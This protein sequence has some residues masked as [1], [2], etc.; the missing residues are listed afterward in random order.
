MTRRHKPAPKTF[1]QRQTEQRLRD[2]GDRAVVEDMASRFSC[3]S[4]VAKDFAGQCEERLV[5]L[6]FD[7]LCSELALG[8][9]ADPP[10]AA[11]PV[12]DALRELEAER[13]R[14]RAALSQLRERLLELTRGP[15]AH[16]HL[17]LPISHYQ[18]LIRDRLFP[19]LKLRPV[20]NP[21]VSGEH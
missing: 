21:A 7:L 12:V 3:S 4:G 17:S 18:G 16:Q 6:D 2:D 13:R 15:A 20:Q 5:D 9:W 14:Y 10:P 1:Q 8:F 19:G 11:L